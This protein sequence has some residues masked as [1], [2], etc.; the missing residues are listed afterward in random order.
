VSLE[1]AE[2]AI[3]ALQSSGRLHRAE[4]LESGDGMT[5]DRALAD[6]CENI[7]LMRSGQGRGKR[8]MRSWLVQA[9]LHRGPLTDGQKAAVKLMLSSKDRTVGIQGYAGT[10]KT[11]MLRRARALAEKNGYRLMGLAPSASAVKTLA[12]EA[13]IDE[14][15][16]RGVPHSNAVRLSLTRRREQQNK[17][18]PIPVE[19]PKEPRVRGI[20]VR[21]HD[22]TGYDGLAGEAELEQF[23]LANA[24][25]H[26]CDEALV[27][28]FHKRNLRAQMLLGPAGSAMA[29]HLKIQTFSD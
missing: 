1:A 22:L 20:A 10:G 26:R 19:L 17:P 29:R 12:A 27:T 2:R 8:I 6:E 16:K 28:L 11:T 13:G 15:L 7:G 9:R 23:V 21:D 24:D 4:S 18:P 14:A 5:T 3:G 25:T